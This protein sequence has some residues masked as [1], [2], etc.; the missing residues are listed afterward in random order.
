MGG[1]RGLV[2]IVNESAVAVVISCEGGQKASGGEGCVFTAEWCRGRVC[3]PLV[4]V[5]VAGE[6]AIQSGGD[7]EE[8][9]AA[10]GPQPI[11]SVHSNEKGRAG[12]E[13]PGAREKG[14]G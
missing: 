1:D 5:Y 8:R 2:V 10:A 13:D 4:F 11:I 12:A 3:S 6:K 9:G 7:S 14:L